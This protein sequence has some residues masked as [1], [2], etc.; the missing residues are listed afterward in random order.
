MNSSQARVA[1]ESFVAHGAEDSRASG[2]FQAEIDNA[3][4]TFY[5]AVLGAHD[6]QRPLCTV[7]HTL[8]PFAR[9]GVEVRN[10]RLQ[11]DHHFGNCVLHLRVIG[12]GAGQGH[13]TLGL[14]RGNGMIE[15]TLGQSAVHVR[16]TQKA[17]GEH[18]QY[19]AVDSRSTRWQY[20]P[21]IAVGNE[22][23]LDDGVVT[24]R[25]TH[26]EYVP[27]LLDRVSRRVARHKGMNHLRLSRVAHV[28]G[29]QTESGPD[30]REATEHLSSGEAV[31]TFDPLGF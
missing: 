27:R 8:R 25:C 30:G 28:H 5:C 21:Y 1:E 17:P 13:R 20:S 15:G 3:P 12:H 16:E 4:R 24:A 18:R 31:S 29:V 23:V 11:F 22:G 14:G 26:A 6:L 9:N 10:D 19:K 7:V 2:Y